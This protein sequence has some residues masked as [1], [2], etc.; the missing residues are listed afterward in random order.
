M[1]IKTKKNPRNNAEKPEKRQISKSQTQSI[2][3]RKET[4]HSST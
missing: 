4:R 1:R 3:E 2:E